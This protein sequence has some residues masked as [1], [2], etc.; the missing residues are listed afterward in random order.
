ML[1]SDLNVYT[2]AAVR[3]ADRHAIEVAGIPAFKLMQRAAAAALGVIRMRFPRVRHLYIV[4]GAGNNGGDGYALAALALQSGL[5]VD[6]EE[7]AS[8]E[9]LS[10]TAQQARTFWQSQ[11]AKATERGDSLAVDAIFGIGLSRPA[12]GRYLAAIQHLNSRCEPIVALD[13]PSGLDAKTGFAVGEAV[14]A[15]LTIT[16]IGAKSGLFLGDAQ[17]YVGELHIDD[18][19]VKIQA[20]A[21]VEPE[22]R[23]ERPRRLFTPPRALDSHKG[24]FGHV[25]AVGGRLGMPGALALAAQAA[26]RVGAGKVTA[27]VNAESQCSLHAVAPEIMTTTDMRDPLRSDSS[28]TV[29]L[30]GPGLGRDEMATEWLEAVL[31]FAK[32]TVIDADG[33]FMLGD[34]SR[35]LSGCVLTPHPLEAARLLGTTTEAVQQ[36]RLRSGTSLAEKFGAVVVLKGHRTIVCAPSQRPVMQLAGNPGLATAGSGDVLAGMIAGLLAQG[37]TAFDAAIA[38]VDWHAQAGDRAS[39]RC[40]EAGLV[41]RELLQELA[42]WPN[43][44]SA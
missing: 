22:F 17:R 44:R 29:V 25:T 6:V 40:G 21:D 43:S 4:C 23:I 11:P 8:V 41:A 26:L 15:T 19:A 33:L 3:L 9:K 32:P 7:L 20:V 24:S 13:V 36:E 38:G 5:S 30:I 12:T 14:L 27:L 34:R 16:F 28:S 2:P 10:K 1:A 42:L 35:N 31:A 39:R 18:L 37:L